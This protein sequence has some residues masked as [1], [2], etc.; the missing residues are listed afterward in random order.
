MHINKGYYLL[1]SILLL[2]LIG[3]SFA[4]CM[5]CPLPGY[6]GDFCK[7]NTMGRDCYDQGY[8]KGK[9]AG[10][11]EGYNMGINE[12]YSNGFEKGLTYGK[13]TCP[14]CPECP[15][16]P[17]Y[18]TYY[19]SNYPYPY[20]YYSFSYPLAGYGGYWQGYQDASAK[21]GA[22]CCGVCPACAT[23]GNAHP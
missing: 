18:P 23:C 16:C 21:C 2:V 13:G 1:F 22:A 17:E 6:G 10:Y 5:G 15:K 19:P 20:Y 4:G 3:S 8:E 9:D 14:T 12:G 7:T 11:K